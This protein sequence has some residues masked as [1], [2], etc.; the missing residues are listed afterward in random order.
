MHINR[1]AVVTGASHGVGRAI[2]EYLSSNGW[3]LLLV[4]RSEAN[5]DEVKASILQRYEVK[6]DV[7][8]LDLSDKDKRYRL[9][10]LLCSDSEVHALVHCA[11]STPDPDMHATLVNTSYDDIHETMNTIIESSTWLLKEF[12]A[13]GNGS[14]R[15]YIQ[16][17]SDWANPGSHG[18]PVFSAAKAYLRH[19]AHT[20]RKEAATFKTDITTIVSGDI[21]SFDIDWE[22]P[23]WRFDD[24]I[25]DVK[26]EL[27]DTRIALI[28]ICEAVQFCLDRRLARVDEI[29]LSPLDPEYD[30]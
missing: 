5:L 29:V 3:N 24:P 10:D 25:E 12:L 14:S 20:C 16:I 22:Q 13:S 17:G 4:A 2:S 15:R 28:D 1:R 6:V 9:K 26:A 19:L 23:K 30:Y 18:P 7:L 21:A 11:S 8:S 27:G